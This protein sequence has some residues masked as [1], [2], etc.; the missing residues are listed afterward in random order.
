M[1]KERIGG[2]L[3]G[4]GRSSGTPRARS[5]YSYF[6]Y[7]SDIIPDFNIFTSWTEADSW[8]KL[9]KIQTDTLRYRGRSVSDWGDDVRNGFYIYGE[10]PAYA[11]LLARDLDSQFNM[12]QPYRDP[13]DVRRSLRQLI[14]WDNDPSWELAKPYVEEEQ[15][16]VRAEYSGCDVTTAK[17]KNSTDGLITTIASFIKCNRAENKGLA[18]Y[19]EGH[20]G[21]AL[22]IGAETINYLANLGWDVLVLDMPMSGDNYVPGQ[23]PLY[24]YSYAF[25][26]IGGLHPIAQFMLPIKLAVDW[27]L[28]KRVTATN[29]VISIGRSGGGWASALYS[30]LD[31]RIEYSVAISGIVPQS[32]RLR[33]DPYESGDYE[34]LAPAVF[35]YLPYEHLMLAA[36]SKGAFY[37][38]N[39]NDSCCFHVAPDDEFIGYIGSS[40]QIYKRRVGFY[41]DP[42]YTEHSA[43][44][45]A[46]EAM[47]VFLE[48]P[49]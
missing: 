17:L 30:N 11:F 29:H 48:S 23:D 45:S 26:D 27:G 16:V 6:S 20:G 32:I 4:E 39:Q 35:S 10:S 34:Q 24:H 38:Y 47:M 5:Q 21:F 25:E 28:N 44:V 41:I 33:R 14:G 7:Q 36:G 13:K 22:D 19:L 18:V 12:D 43:S 1:L 3:S 46:L 40:A 49:S 37:I 8:L 15:T 31:E 2:R 42:E 9:N